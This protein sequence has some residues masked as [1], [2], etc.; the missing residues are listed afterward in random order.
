MVHASSGRINKNKDKDCVQYMYT[1]Q[2]TVRIKNLIPLVVFQH[3]RI[4]G[5]F[6]RV[7]KVV[8]RNV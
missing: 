6:T 7:V 5:F 8:S 2:C 4:V 3:V 1:V